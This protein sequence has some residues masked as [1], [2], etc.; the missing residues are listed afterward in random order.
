MYFSQET[1]TNPAWTEAL[2]RMR[3]EQTTDNQ[4]RVLQEI[5]LRAK[6]ILPVMFSEPVTLDA[7]GRLNVPEG[8]TAKVALLTGGDE[9]HYFPAFTCQE[10]WKKWQ[11]S[12]G[13]HMAVAQFDDYVDLLN[14]DTDVAGVII[15]PFGES[16][17]LT[18]KEVGQLKKTKD[19]F[20][21]SGTQTKMEPG[22][23]VKLRSPGKDI[24]V[25][26]HAI[27][28]YLKTQPRVKSG[29]LCMMQQEGK[30]TFLIVL[31]APNDRSISDGV[32]K[33][34]LPHLEGIPL[35]IAPAMS[36]LGER[37]MMSFDP[38]YGAKK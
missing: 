32:A 20:A 18:R 14:K 36:E 12:S 33:A 26:T 9:N 30:E 29:Y 21:F 23:K 3:K 25:L 27:T 4:G 24:S 8:T 10:E 11:A 13:Q 1:I 19:N 2:R 28:D 5:A 15:D 34:A 31:S 17:L 22:V 16:F 35:N 37:V 38:F 7:N 6:F